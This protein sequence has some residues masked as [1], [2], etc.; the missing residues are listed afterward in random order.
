MGKILRLDTSG[1]PTEWISYQAAII[2][3]AKGNVVWQLGEGEGDVLFR[4]GQNRIT[5]IMSQIVTAPIIAV[6]G[7][8]GA[9]ARMQ[10]PPPL[11]NSELFRR[12][13]YMCAYCGNVFKSLHLTRDHIIPRS[14]GG[15]DKW[16]NCVAACEKCNHKKA[17][18]ML[19]DTNMKLLYVPYAP[20]KVEAL[21]LEN[22]KVL[23]CQMDYLLMFLPEHSRVWEQLE[24]A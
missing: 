21:V 6:R 14:R 2:Y 3:H 9:R 8:L 19:E 23:A 18:H 11:T 1:T 24:A 16:T 12:D 13:R 10:L 7:E 4:G 5:G 17:D 15:L 22:R 20:N